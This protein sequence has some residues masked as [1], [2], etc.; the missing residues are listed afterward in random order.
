MESNKIET[1]PNYKNVW[2]D[3]KLV[4]K[5]KPKAK[6]KTESDPIQRINILSSANRAPVTINR[7]AKLIDAITKMMM[8]NYSQLP[9]L[10][11]PKSVIGFIT[12]ESI[13]YAIT[14]G[15]NSEHVKE[16]LNYDYT[17]LKYD[18]PLLEAL[19]IVI[20]KEYI[21]VQKK[22]KS[23]S[24][25]ITLADVSSE[26][27]ILT[28]PF[29]LLEQIENL[30]RL[31]LNDKFL[32][33]ELMDFCKND[34]IERNIDSI[35]DLSFGQYIRLIEKPDNW[36]KLKLNIERVTFIKE[37]DLVRKIR[38][39]IMHFN[40]EGISKEQKQSLLNMSKFLMDIRKYH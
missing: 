28:E 36:N 9:V 12:W 26:F 22:D 19:N 13:G 16:Y 40:P 20:E 6:S 3:G 35:D 1:I 34:N 38:N 2:I 14:N 11:T 25:I 24:G 21:L 15:V 8:N 39:D 7:D 5:H 29:L 18:T 17:I 30:I 27:L 31:L 37:L 23:I 33:Q 4:L 10:S 32:I